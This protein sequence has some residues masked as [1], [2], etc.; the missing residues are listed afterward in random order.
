MRNICLSLWLHH[1]SPRSPDWIQTNGPYLR[2]ILLYSTELPNYIGKRDT[3][4]NISMYSTGRSWSMRTD[5]KLNFRQLLPLLKHNHFTSASVKDCR[6]NCIYNLIVFAEWTGLEP[7]ASC[8]TGRHSN[9][10]NYHS[11][12]EPKDGIEPP[13]Y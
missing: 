7:V 4:S 1:Q 2:R 3:T 12:F 8:V 11:I 13:T 5:H 10:L 9:Q 6:A